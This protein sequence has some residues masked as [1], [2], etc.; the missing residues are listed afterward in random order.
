MRMLN[1]RELFRATGFHED[2]IIAPEFQ[3]K[4]LTKTAQIRM[5]GNAVPPDLAE[6]VTR[7]ALGLPQAA[8]EEPVSVAPVSAERE[9][10]APRRQPKAARPHKAPRPVR[11]RVV[12]DNTD[13]E[14][15]ELL[16]SG[17]SKRAI[18]A[19]IKRVGMTRADAEAMVEGN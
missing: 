5:V 17:D 8:P 10:R 4:P 19:L 3:G 11:A 9:K 18:E 14:V 2:Y 13:D 12:A 16:T 6:Q 1:P 7:C 15:M